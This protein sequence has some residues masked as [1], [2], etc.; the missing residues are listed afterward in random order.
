MQSP[1]D[2]DPIT[3]REKGYTHSYWN[4]RNRLFGWIILYRPR[5]KIVKH[6]QKPTGFR[7]SE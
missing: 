6:L 2:G 3:K 5:T 7:L 4:F 1:L